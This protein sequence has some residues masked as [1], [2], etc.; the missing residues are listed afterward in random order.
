MRSSSLIPRVA[1][2]LKLSP[3][4][5]RSQSLA[6]WLRNRAD[7]VGERRAR[8]S[9]GRAPRGWAESKPRTPRGR[10]GSDRTATHRRRPQP[11]LCRRQPCWSR[12]LHRG[13]HTGTREDPKGSARILGTRR[14]GVESG[15]ERGAHDSARSSYKCRLRAGRESCADEFKGSDHARHQVR[16]LDAELRLKDIAV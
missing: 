5:K 14:R 16:R 6:A 3:V 11:Y 4:R 1:A 2:T 15:D 12:H 9:P 7:A 13:A 10:C 8:C